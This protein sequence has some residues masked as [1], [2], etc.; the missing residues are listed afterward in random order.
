M[1]RA[2]CLVCQAARGSFS[3]ASIH[4]KYI[5]FDC[6]CINFGGNT[7]NG[8]VCHIKIEY[9]II[10]HNQELVNSFTKIF[11]KV[12]KKPSANE[13]KGLN[14][15]ILNTR[16]IKYFPILP[17]RKVVHLLHGIGAIVIEP[18]GDD[19]AESVDEE[20]GFI[21]AGRVIGCRLEVCAELLGVVFNGV[22]EPSE[23]LGGGARSDACIRKH[24]HKYLFNFG[25]HIRSSFHKFVGK[26]DNFGRE[27]LALCLYDSVIDGIGKTCKNTADNTDNNAYHHC[28]ISV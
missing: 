27:L 15:A 12:A 25:L 1:S 22:K 17:H 21:V 13:A 5:L 6:I 16:S 9:Y 28:H 8:K 2:F 7:N 26:T 24:I 10:P 4:A 11:S 18:S 3:T 19:G 14:F 23:V 20:G